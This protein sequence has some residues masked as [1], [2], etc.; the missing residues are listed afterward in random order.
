MK[1]IIVIV[2]CLLS[3]QSPFAQTTAQVFGVVTEIGTHQPLE[4]VVVGI[5][6]NNQSI[7]TNEAGEY[8]IA[9]PTGKKWTLVFFKTGYKTAETVLEPLKVG[10]QRQIDVE[11]AST[12]SI[13]EVTIRDQKLKNS[14]MVREDVKNFKMLPTTTANLES[15]LPH[16]ALGTNAGTGGELSSFETTIGTKKSITVLNYTGLLLTSVTTTIV[17][18]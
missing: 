12:S 2:G 8:G 6:E 16:I 13:Q 11:L 14:G 9:V 18:I 1:Q 3:L 17:D 7:E 5:K 15:V 4:K 10:S